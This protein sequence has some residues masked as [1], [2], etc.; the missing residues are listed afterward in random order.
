VRD[1]RKTELLR[2]SGS[3]DDGRPRYDPDPLRPTD[4]DT[5]RSILS[6]RKDPHYYPE[7]DFLSTALAQIR[8]FRGC[9]LGQQ[10]PLRGPQRADLPASFLSED[11]RNLGIVLN[12][13]LNRPRTKKRLLDELKQFCEFVEDI[14]TK[15]VA[16][17][18]ECFLHERGFRDAIPSTRLSDGTLRYL[19]LLT[20]LCHPEPPPLICIEDPEI[21]LHPDSLPRLAELLLEASQRTQLVV[22]T[23]SD[24]LVSALSDTPEAVIICERDDDGS[25]LRRLER[26]PLKEWLDKYSL[27]ELWRMGEMGGNP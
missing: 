14:T 24:V 18:V 7:L 5:Q 4:I 12:D 23:H 8:L 10:S 9:D 1:D 3:D 19:W 22:T 2:F 15:I 17:T 27:G 25:H 11:G 26:E 13:L 6:Q 20:I 16:G 21:A